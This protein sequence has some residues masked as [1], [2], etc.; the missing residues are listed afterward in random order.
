MKSLMTFPFFFLVCTVGAAEHVTHGHLEAD[1]AAAHGGVLVENYY[2]HL[3]M[4]AQKP[5][6]N[7]H[8]YQGVWKVHYKDGRLN[9]TKATLLK[10]SQERAKADFKKFLFG[11]FTV[12]PQPFVLDQFGSSVAEVSAK[13]FAGHFEVRGQHRDITSE[14]ASTQF[15]LEADGPPLL[16]HR[17]DPTKLIRPKSLTYFAFGGKYLAKWLT[18]GPD[19]DHIVEVEV[20]GAPVNL[21]DGVQVVFKAIPHSSSDFLKVG[22]TEDAEILEL[23]VESGQP[24]VLESVRLRVVSQVFKNDVLE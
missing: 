12:D 3:P 15:A 20:A 22:G 24:A 1:R 8:T 16:L 19:S 13:L 5:L 23:P 17:L 11:I 21:K 4:F 7:P 9:V 6:E 2:Y 10:F 18:V 14:I